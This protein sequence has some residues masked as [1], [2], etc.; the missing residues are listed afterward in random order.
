MLIINLQ[1]SN[2]FSSYTSFESNKQ[3]MKFQQIT[4]QKFK[5]NNYPKNVEYAKIV[6]NKKT[7]Q[8][9]KKAKTLSLNKN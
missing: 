4:E 1:N 8:R 7:D 2:F 6:S 3:K 5:Q 9:N